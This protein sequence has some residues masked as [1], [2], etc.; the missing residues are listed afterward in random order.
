MS[1]TCNLGEGVARPAI[2]C[3]LMSLPVLLLHR[4]LPNET[5]LEVITVFTGLLV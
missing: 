1:A 5:I 3:V 2:R 4:R